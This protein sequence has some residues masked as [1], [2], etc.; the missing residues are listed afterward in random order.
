MT[1]QVVDPNNRQVPGYP[2]APREGDP[3]REAAGK[4]RA[5]GHGY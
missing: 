5:I 2:K 3:Q 1:T 4:T